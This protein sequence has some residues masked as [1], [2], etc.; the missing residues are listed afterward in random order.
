MLDSGVIAQSSTANSTLTSKHLQPQS[1]LRS[2]RE[3]VKLVLAL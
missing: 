3:R 2:W 1:M